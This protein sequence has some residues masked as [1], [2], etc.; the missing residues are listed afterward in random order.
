MKKL[1]PPLLVNS[2]VLAWH[3]IKRDPNSRGEGDGGG[4]AIGFLAADSSYSFWSKS[5]SRTSVSS[6]RFSPHP[7]TPSPQ[8]FGVSLIR[9]DSFI[10]RIYGERGSPVISLKLVELK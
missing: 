6:K 9:L 4:G 3:L 2:D 10:V 7:P 8:K 1:A 5:Q